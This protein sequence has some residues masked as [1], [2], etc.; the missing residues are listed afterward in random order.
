MGPARKT[1]CSHAPREGTS[2]VRRH[3]AAA[4]L[5]RED[6]DVA[7]VAVAVAAAKEAA[8]AAAA[9]A[10]AVGNLQSRVLHKRMLLKGVSQPGVAAAV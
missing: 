2:G 8:A 6:V 4:G 5:R 9:A 10:A 1:W 3:R 7:Q